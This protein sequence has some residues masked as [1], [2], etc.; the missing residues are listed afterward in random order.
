MKIQLPNG[1]QLDLDES[2][3]LEEKLE[4][5]ENLTEEW[6]PV[7]KDNWYSNSVKYFLDSLA[8]Y[9]VWHKEP[10]DKGL[11][12]KEVMS[13]KK[14]EKLVR[15]KKTSKTI[16]FSDLSTEYKEALFGERGAE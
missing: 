3:T 6:M 2:I 16:N 1:S 4:T 8:N 11:E 15:F 13:R 5:V 10:D 9:I 12:D 7:I 14:M